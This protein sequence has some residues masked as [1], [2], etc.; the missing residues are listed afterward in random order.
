MPNLVQKLKE[1]LGLFYRK[2]EPVKN[3]DIFEP[4]RFHTEPLRFEDI[5]NK[6]NEKMKRIKNKEE[7]KMFEIDE[8]L[9]RSY[10]EV[11]E[12]EIAKEKRP[13]EFLVEIPQTDGSVLYKGI[14]IDIT[15]IFEIDDD[16]GYLKYYRMASQSDTYINDLSTVN[17]QTSG[18][19]D[20]HNARIRR[21]LAE[22]RYNRTKLMFVNLIE[23]EASG[24]PIGLDTVKV[25]ILEFMHK[26]KKFF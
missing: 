22:P 14:R 4:I 1:F 7:Q 5:E 12:V 23:V 19:E 10:E 13:G 9:K 11:S 16:Y 18:S 6:D 20:S 26:Y 2:R 8:A 3:D 15:A 17:F 24:I 21:V 25:P